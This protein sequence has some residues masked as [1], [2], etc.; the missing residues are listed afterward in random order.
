MVSNHQIPIVKWFPQKMKIRHV[1]KTTNQTCVSSEKKNRKH[2]QKTSIKHKK[3][4]NNIKQNQNPTLILELPRP[5][6]PLRSFHV[7]HGARPA[8]G[9]S[10]RTAGSAKMRRANMLTAAVGFC[11]RWFGSTSINHWYWSC[12]NEINK[13][14]FWDLDQ[15]KTVKNEAAVTRSNED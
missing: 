1:N 11:Q 7:L 12:H 10:G 6:R 4:S 3:T 9:A 14:T 15:W 2:E 13:L 5:R 8:T